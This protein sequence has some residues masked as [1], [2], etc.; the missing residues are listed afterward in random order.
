MNATLNM[1]KSSTTISLF[2][3]VLLGMLSAV[4]ATQPANADFNAGQQ[5]FDAGNVNEAVT[6]WQAAAN[7]G[8]RRAMLELG[9]LYATG[10]GV[11]QDYVEAH[12]WLNLAASRGEAAA[13]AERNALAAKMTPAQLE[14]AQQQAAAFQSSVGGAP[15]A[16]TAP[17]PEAIREAQELLTQ[18]G[19]APDSA[20]GIWGDDTARAYQLFL[21]DAGLPAADALTPT[22]LQ[23]MRDLAGK[24]PGGAQPPSKPA[25]VS[26]P[27]LHQAAQA[28]DI[29]AIEAALA[30]GVDVDMRDGQ[31]WTALMHAVNQG[32][33]VL[34]DLLLAADTAVNLRAPDGAT[35]LFMAVPLGNTEIVSMLMRAGA[36][37]AIRGPNGLTAVD[38]A[39]T[40]YGEVE[41]L[42]AEVIALV[43]GKPWAEV[44]DDAA[45][46]QVET[47]ED[48]KAYLLAYPSGRHADDATRRLQQFEEERQLAREREEEE[49][50]LARERE[51]QEQQLAREREEQ[52][53]KWPRGTKF[54]DCYGCPEMV[55]VPAGSF[56]M[57][58][59]DGD[60]DNEEPV[61]E[62]TISK[63]FAVGV[64][65]VTVGEFD[66]F[67]NESGY[68]PSKGCKTYKWGK[69]K[70]RSAS[71]WNKPEFSQTGAHPVVCVHWDDAQEYVRW[72]SRKTGG[73]YRLLS[74]SEW[75]YA[76]RAGTGTRYWWGDKVGS[77]RANCEGCGS[78]WDDE[79]TAPVGSFSANAFG[80]Y[81][82]HGNVWEWVGDCWN[83]SYRGAPTDG[84]AWESGECRNRML[85]GGAW[86]YSPWYLRSAFRNS[87]STRK[88]SSRDGFRVAKTLVP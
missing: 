21:Q 53:R 74:E 25:S 5:A 7:A 10:L 59:P 36:D 62:V 34:V 33:P 49:Q 35:A 83:D 17:P 68:S 47:E 3:V 12:K 37:I 76:A 11:M 45:W 70:D 40:K 44:E 88:R 30:S 31:G 14:S 82:V 54:R 16:D 42:D 77:N 69:W 67:V 28:G 86:N 43:E 85:R 26:P 51:E 6:Q 20:D 38:V 19:Y 80:L 18:L 60:D 52:E 50:R 61:H 9:R 66:L 71:G 4:V 81:D 57:G 56:T 41:G 15:A 46:E 73:T 87:E 23:A 22:T 8:D 79:Q 39:R 32:Y 58:S 84:S 55:I 75:E 65:E 78:R 29:A 63:P 72:L 1:K 13:L 2:S 27:A 24:S 48:I 64:Y